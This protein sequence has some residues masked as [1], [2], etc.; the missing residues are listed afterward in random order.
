MTYACRSGYHLARVGAPLDDYVEMVVLKYLRGT[1]IHLLLRTAARSTSVRC[2]P[3]RRVA[4]P[5]G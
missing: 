3:A 4:G 2:T 1:D 5:A